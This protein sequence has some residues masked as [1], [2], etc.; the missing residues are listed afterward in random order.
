M[1]WDVPW[2][3]VVAGRV[4]GLKMNG[5]HLDIPPP[6]KLSTLPGTERDRAAFQP[7]AAQFTQ[8]I[9]QVRRC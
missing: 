7:V 8:L 6:E 3:G 9:E 5:E 4:F 2:N 1:T